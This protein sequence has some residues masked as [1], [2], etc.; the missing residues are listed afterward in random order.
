MQDNSASG[1]GECLDCDL[2][3]QERLNYFTGQF[4][5]ERDFKDEQNYHIGKHR[6]HNRYLHGW[7]TVCG[8]KVTQHPNSAC[9]DRFIII[10]PGLALD[11]CGREIVVRDN[12]YVDLDKHLAPRHS[13]GEAE[14][15]HLLVSLCYAECDTEFV[16]ALY[17][18][19]GC[20]EER[21][22]PNRVRE[23]FD[24]QLSY[25]DELPQTY[26]AEAVDIAL[27]WSTTINLRDATR[28]VL[29]S[30]RNFLY[31][32]TEEGQ[33]YVYETNHY[34]LLRSAG[35]QGQGVDLALSA[36]GDFI[37]VIRYGASEAGGEEAY[38]L[39]VLSREDLET[40]INDFHLAA[41]SLDRTQPMP[42]VIVP[43]EDGSGKVFALDNVSPEQRIVVWSTALNTALAAP[44]D[45]SSATYAVMGADT[46]TAFTVSPDGTWLFTAAADQVQAI[47]VETLTEPTTETYPIEI[48]KPAL[49]AVSGDS[50]RLFAGTESGQLRVFQIPDSTVSSLLGSTFTEIGVGVDLDINEP[51]SLMASPSGRWAYV[52]NRDDEGKGQISVVDIGRLVARAGQAV[53]EP[54]SVL[55][56]PQ[57]LALDEDGR[58]L[59]AVGLGNDHLCG[60]VSVLHVNE[61][62]CHELL[63][64]ALEECP[65][66]P[67]DT[68]VPL[69]VVLDYTYGDVVTDQRIDNRIRPLVP[70]TETLR[71]LVLCALET[72]TG[73]QGPEGPEGRP[74][75]PGVEEATVINTA[76]GSEASASVTYEE[77][78]RRLDFSFTIPAGEP[79]ED[80]ANGLGLNPDLPKILDVEWMRPDLH[81]NSTLEEPI[82]WSKFDELLKY[83]K[84]SSIDSVIQ[85]DRR[86][87]FTIYF[88]KRMI[89]VNRQTLKVWIDY[90]GVILSDLFT[91]LGLYNL[92]A[93]DDKILLCD[94]N[95]YGAIVPIESTDERDLTPNTKEPFKWA[96]SFIPYNLKI[97]ENLL[98]MFSKIQESQ[99]DFWKR[100]DLP[101]VN[102]LLKGDFIREASIKSIMV[103]EFEKSILDANNIGGQIGIN[104]QRSE[105]IQGGKNP[106]GNLTQGGNFEDWFFLEPPS[107]NSNSSPTHGL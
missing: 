90:P 12:V 5:A 54:V 101:C 66:C 55:P 58:T 86:G 29:D 88:N 103:D 7:G 35:I 31:V 89:G 74:G 93:K 52:L 105:T 13:S 49:L 68:C 30:E 53:G 47:E 38:H 20:D 43:A 45:P 84:N 50:Q 67:E 78:E 92:L 61:E 8:L 63:W 24:I 69:S 96:V 94:L 33:L 37:Y 75:P 82:L 10:E 21:C 81:K 19:C 28:I 3:S 11:C 39:R 51:I 44:S 22:E 106:S 85:G 102:I 79:G 1:M 18:D 95:L 56:A 80:G 107:N 32:L 23:G 77:A 6:Q 40:S 9:Q 26:N 73:R 99:P 98:R 14:G 41:G 59:Y 70:S 25:V 60:G 15:Q 72:G 65:E 17:S 36:D 87:L 48:T 104:R 27:D 100:F 97:I 71:Q 62:A 83:D 46:V 57:G 76:I 4:L 42:Q 16:P 64:K 34:C 2:P 91:P